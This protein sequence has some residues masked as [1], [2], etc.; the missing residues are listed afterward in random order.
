MRKPGFIAA[1]V[2]LLAAAPAS[3]QDGIP[4][5]LRALTRGLTWTPVS[6][7]TL[8]FPTQHPQGMIRI[9]ER[10]YISSVEIIEPTRRHD[11]PRDGL[12][13]TAGRGRGHLFEVDAEGKLLRSVTLGEGDVYHPG[14][15]DFDGTHL[16]V[17]VAEYRPNSASIVYR[18]D[19]ATM[20][21]EEVF[22]FR[23][24]VGGLV[25]DRASNTL[26]GVS[27]GSRRFYA[28]PLG[29]E[30]RPTNLATAP[31]ALRRPN[32]S[33]YIDYQDC[34]SVGAG[35]ALCSGL[36]AYRPQGASGPVF[37]LGGVELVD[38][39]R[40]SAVFHLPVEL[41][42]ESGLPMT[43]NPFFVAPQGRGLRFWFAP[44]DDRTRIFTYDV[45]PR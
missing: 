17:P 6:V 31:E 36:N 21:A 27:W 25:M 38:L 1:L 10:F 41:W 40:G 30:G 16:W 22:R 28:W 39:A 13:R 4:D 23:D 44:E 24:H 15:L 32:P 26:H 2:A 7:V 29:A 9:G 42:T 18:V 20:R 35:L 3:A 34:H 43:Q 8:G 19:P 12:D 45:E 5:R 33:H 14:G 11:A 37:A